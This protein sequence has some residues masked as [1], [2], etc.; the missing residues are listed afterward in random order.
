[1]AAITYKQLQTAVTGLATE[2]TRTADAVDSL[3]TWIAT[4]ADDTSRVAEMIASINVDPATVAETTEVARLMLGLSEAS[5]SYV[6]GS[7]HTA[8]VFTAAHEQARTTHE[9][10]N[11]AAGRS[12]VGRAVYDIDRIWFAQE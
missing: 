11:Q 4:E 12:P 7:R 6:Q 8:K 2:M 5:I 9:A 1:M 3:T 10:F